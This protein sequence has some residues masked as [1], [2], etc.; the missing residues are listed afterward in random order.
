MTFRELRPSPACAG[1]WLHP[2]VGTWE[3]GLPDPLQADTIAG[4]RGG[5]RRVQAG[6]VV[7]FVRRC[8]RGGALARVL[9]D[10]FLSPGRALA[11]AHALERL[12]PFGLSPRCL[13]VQHEGRLL[14]RLTVA[15][16]E[17]PG[18]RDL[19]ALARD[20]ERDLAGM[21]RAAGEVVR[22]MHEAGVSHRDLNA[23]NI[24]AR[25][26]ADGWRAW[27]IDL[28]D[29]RLLPSPVPMRR[30]IAE[31]LRLCRSVDKWE[32]S[33]TTPALARLGFLRGA[34]PA[35][36][37]RRQAWRRARRAHDLRRALGREP[38]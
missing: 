36:A 18:A 27:V 3:R 32:S 30:R 29:A 26:D 6:G 2:D 8:K 24:L 38:R 33:A 9:P 14:H 23:S 13:G 22:R 11:E 20:G 1:L 34:L 37:W 21:A 16:E 25:R 7:A 31:I 28:D 17:V 19:L 12:A 35:A 4:G 15:V 10:A 5:C